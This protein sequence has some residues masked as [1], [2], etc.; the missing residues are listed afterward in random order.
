M[1]SSS[2]SRLT[3]RRRGRAARRLP[4]EAVGVEQIAGPRLL[5]GDV[6]R[7]PLVS[8]L[9]SSTSPRSVRSRWSPSAASTTRSRIARGWRR[10]ASVAICTGAARAASSRPIRNA[11]TASS[12]TAAAASHGRHA[13]SRAARGIGADPCA[14]RKLRLEARPHRGAVVAAALGHVELGRGLEHARSS[15]SASRHSPHT[16]E[17]RLDFAA[18]CPLGVVERVGDELFFG[19]VGHE[20]CPHQRRQRAPHLGHRAEDAVPGRGRALSRARR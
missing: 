20:L 3:Q 1:G 4:I 19:D 5:G 8:A 2:P 12:R 18:R 17:V 10:R 11:P 14:D 16:R 6:D 9:T 15:S 13:A 7:A